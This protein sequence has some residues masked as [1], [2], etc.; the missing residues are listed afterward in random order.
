[1][2]DLAATKF[3]LKVYREPGRS[4][5][6]LRAT[7]LTYRQNEKGKVGIPYE[8]H[9]S[10]TVANYYLLTMYCSKLLQ[11]VNIHLNLKKMLDHILIVSSYFKWLH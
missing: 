4:R 6:G 3:A 5:R 11:I 10:C 9:M 1:M 7:V 2:V 8:H